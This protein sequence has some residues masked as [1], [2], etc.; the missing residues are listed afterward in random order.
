VYCDQSP[1]W[2][3]FEDSAISTVDAAIG[4]VLST[5]FGRPIETAVGALQQTGLRI[6]SITAAERV[7][8]RKIAGRTDPKHGAAALVAIRA[9]SAP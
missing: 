2:A 3:D 9:R 8:I 1:C 5:V 7:Q 6:G 4:T